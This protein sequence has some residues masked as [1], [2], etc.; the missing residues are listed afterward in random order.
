MTDGTGQLDYE[1]R[2][3]SAWEADY[4]G[5][6]SVLRQGKPERILDLLKARRPLVGD[7]FDLLGKWI[8]DQTRPVGNAL[9]VDQHAAANLVDELKRIWLDANRKKRVP[10]IQLDEIIEEA[11]E[12]IEQER[13]CVVDREGVRELIRRPASRRK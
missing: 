12:T 3:R 9:K 8:D 2:I 10:G 11:C 4:K 13:G 1:A 7:D 5:A 6:I